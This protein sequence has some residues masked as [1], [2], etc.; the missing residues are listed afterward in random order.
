MYK[1]QL[2]DN[3]EKFANR[4]TELFTDE[5]EVQLANI[6]TDG[7]SYG[8]HHRYGEMA[9][10]YCLESLSNRDDI[11]L[12]VYG[13]FLEKYPPGYEVEIIEDS[14]WS[15]AHGVERWRSNCG[16]NTGGNH[17][18]HQHWRGP[19][20]DAFD[21]VRDKLIV[22]YE[23]E[24][25]EY[26]KEFELNTPFDIFYLTVLI[27]F[28]NLFHGYTSEKAQYQKIQ[29]IIEDCKIKLGDINL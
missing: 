17:G 23:N 11:K 12:T 6:A 19:L 7:E 1:R 14:S 5:D 13:E 16:C 2:L 22:L 21:W 20:R 25:N 10:S 26:Y 3:G 24:I 18:W 4:L 27:H 8:H 29:P 9:L 28:L 15:C